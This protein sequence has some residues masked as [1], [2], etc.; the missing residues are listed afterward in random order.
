MED[1]SMS[2]DIKRISRDDASTECI[3]PLM[4]RDDG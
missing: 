3:N 1:G 2:E 4:V